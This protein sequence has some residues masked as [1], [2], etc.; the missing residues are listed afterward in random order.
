MNTEDINFTKYRTQGKK[1]FTTDQIEYWKILVICCI[2]FFLFAC[3]IPTDEGKTTVPCPPIQIDAFSPYWD[4]VWHPAGEIIGFNHIPLDSITYP[5]G[6]E[7]F[8][9]YHYDHNKAGFWL[10]SYNGNNKRRIFPY[11]LESPDWSSDGQWIAF[12]AEHQLYKLKFVNGAVDST[13]L[14]QLTYEGRNFFPAWSPRNNLIAYNKSICDGPNTCGIWVMNA[15]GTNKQ[16]VVNHGNYPDWHPTQ[17]KF[18]Y[19]VRSI[20]E[21]GQVLGDSLLTYNLKSNSYD[22]ITYLEDPN[23]TLRHPQFSPN[24]GRIVFWSGGN[25]WVIDTTGENRHQLTTLKVDVDFGWPFSWRPDGVSIVFTR[26]DPYAWNYDNGTL[27]TLNINSGN[28]K[29]LTTN[30]K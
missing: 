12:E 29:Q 8:G 19:V 17:L 20:G 2:C 27:W 1:I 6:K 10:M 11:Y 7:C 3:D 14:T 16:F 22:F 13:T 25:L 5:Y 23:S 15:D 21:F 9:E 28:I 24:G 26:Y 30:G 4:P 18:L